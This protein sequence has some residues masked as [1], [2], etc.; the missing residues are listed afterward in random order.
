MRA[1]LCLGSQQPVL[2]EVER[3]DRVVGNPIRQQPQDIPRVRV[4]QE[5]GGLVAGR[6][7]YLDPIERKVLKLAGMPL[8]L[9]LRASRGRPSPGSPAHFAAAGARP[10]RAL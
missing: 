5:G 3:D 9:V 1:S 7:M 2:R 8:E 10:L 6:R 4:H